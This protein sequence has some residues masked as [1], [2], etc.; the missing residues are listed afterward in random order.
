MPGCKLRLWLP[1][2]LSESSNQ[3]RKSTPPGKTRD[4]MRSRRRSQAAISCAQERQLREERS[5]GRQ[6]EFLERQHSRGRDRVSKQA[7]CK[8]C[9][10]SKK[11]T[12]RASAN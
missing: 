7:I 12:R 8:D 3:K 4:A 2:N 10:E 1:K 6:T 9:P 5:L 11:P